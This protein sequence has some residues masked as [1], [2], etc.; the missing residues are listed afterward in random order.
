M[1]S[2]C[3]GVSVN[4]FVGGFGCLFGDLWL[5]SFSFLI[6]RF[7]CYN[8]HIHANE[9]FPSTDMGVAWKY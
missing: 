7:F 9:N 5:V 6:V 4:C 8:A 2:G 1:W 3:G